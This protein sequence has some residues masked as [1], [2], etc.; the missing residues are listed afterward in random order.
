[1]GKKK[2]NKKEK[3]VEEKIEE[4]V[5]EPEPIPK[6]EPPKPPPLPV[7]P[8]GAS[9]LWLDGET[10]NR[11]SI[12]ELF[13]YYARNGLTTKCDWELLRSGIYVYIAVIK[14]AG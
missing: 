8:D 3:V 7:I 13:N 4:P 11:K 12:T 1:M 14:R 10:D 9:E 2:K 5:V 6:P